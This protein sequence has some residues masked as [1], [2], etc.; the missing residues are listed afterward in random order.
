MGWFQLDPQSIA[1]RA[2]AAGS[3][4]PSLGASL[5]RGILGFTMVSIGGFAPWAIFGSA[6]HGL[7]GEA[8]LYATCALAFIGLSAPAMHRLI[9]GPGSLGRFYMLFGISFAAYAAVW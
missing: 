5:A 2:R 9:I 1:A 4:A 3:A 7:V 8:G 6:L